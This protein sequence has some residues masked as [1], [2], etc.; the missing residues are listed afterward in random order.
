MYKF[1]KNYYK[2]GDFNSHSFLQ[3]FSVC[4][5]KVSTE[6]D[7]KRSMQ[8]DFVDICMLAILYLGNNHLSLMCGDFVP[9]SGPIKALVEKGLLSRLVRPL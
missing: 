6:N 8:T 1:L 9:A 4:L 3:M 5:F 7:L 2:N